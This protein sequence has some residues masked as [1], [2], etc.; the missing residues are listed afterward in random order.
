MV[1]IVAVMHWVGCNSAVEWSG[2]IDGWMTERPRLG[3]DKQNRKAR[4][5]WL[6]GEV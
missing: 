6:F 5:G 4:D 1:V 2:E 3:S